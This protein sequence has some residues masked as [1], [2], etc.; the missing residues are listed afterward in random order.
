MTHPFEMNEPK[1]TVP[2]II[3]LLGGG[4][5]AAEA[6]RIALSK[7]P[8]LVAADGGADYAHTHKIP[9]THI[10]GDFDSLT[11]FEIWQDK[12]VNLVHLSEQDSTDFEKCLYTFDAQ[13]YLCVGFLGRRM[14]HSLA[15][16]RALVAYPDRFPILIGDGDI[17]FRCPENFTLEMQAGDYISLFPMGPVEGVGSAGLRWPIDGLKFSPG[18][19]IGT[20]NAATGGPIEIK[21]KGQEMLIILPFQ[22]LES[23]IAQL[24]AQVGAPAR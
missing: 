18:G 12:G 22:Y 5:V 21:L 3:T 6:L 10:V 2:N 20:S 8:Y 16:L 9:V 4:P 14:D 13:I 19:Q 17:T 24:A 15:A 7:A 11:T 23:V 1:N